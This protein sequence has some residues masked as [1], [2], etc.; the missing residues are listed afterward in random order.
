[1]QNIN[2]IVF[3]SGLTLVH[4]E[5]NAAPV[6]ALMVWVKAGSAVEKPEEF[7]IAHMCEH[8]V[9]KG[10][11]R[12]GVGEISHLAE[13]A[14]GD[15]NAW[16]S[17]D[18]TVF[19]ITLPVSQ[20]DLGMDILADMLLHPSIDSLELDRERE[21]IL[22]ELRRGEDSP[23]QTLSKEL[24]AASYGE[25][26]YSHPI[27][28]TQKT[29]KAQTAETL[30]AFI[31]RHYIPQNIIVTI[32]G[33]INLKAA[34]KMVAKYWPISVK[35]GE[36]AKDPQKLPAL[37]EALR[38]GQPTLKIVKAEKEESHLALSWSIPS[39]LHQDMPALDILATI[40]GGASSS[41]LPLILR[42]SLQLVHN[43]DAYAFTPGK[44]GIFI[45]SAALE[46]A[47]IENALKKIMAEVERLS[48]ELITQAELAKARFIL[49][50]LALQQMETV[51]DL[52]KD[53]ASNEQLCAN[54][55]E[56]QRYNNKLDMV[57]PAE[58]LRVARRYLLTPLAAVILVPKK[59]NLP[60]KSH[61]LKLLSPSKE[62]AKVH[63]G[64][65]LS[66]DKHGWYHYDLPTGGHIVAQLDDH[67]PLV[68]CSIAYPGG[69]RYETPET[70]G[71]DSFLATL[72]S[73]STKNRS[74]EKMVALLDN[75]AASINGFAGRN[76]IGLQ[77]SFLAANIEETLPL[78]LE[79]LLLP[80]F[81]K[82][83]IA[84]VRH[85]TMERIRS[86][87]DRPATLCRDLLLQGLYG[88]NHPFGQPAGGT[89]ESVAAIAQKAA[90]AARH[91]QIILAGK[92]VIALCG[93]FDPELI[94]EIVADYYEKYALKAQP[95]PA[96][97]PISP[98]KSQATLEK[99]LDKEQVHLSLGFL[100][101][102]F[103][104]AKERWALTL[105]ETILSGQSGRLFTKLRDEE[106]LAYTVNSTYVS[107]PLSGYFQYYIAVSPNKVAKAKEGLLRELS[108]L[109]KY[110]LKAEELE[111]ARNTLLGAQLIENQYLQTR[112]HHISLD[113]I[114]NLGY[115]AYLRFS[116]DLQKITL[117]DIE[118]AARRYLEPD[119][120]IWAQ[121]GPC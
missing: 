69:Q 85:L 119:K 47:S 70:A 17:Y 29:I 40:L 100:A 102:N 42:D 115:D 111:K 112:T 114:Y 121:V 65:A 90:L 23:Y 77:G 101:P 28:G 120:A 11:E 13:S 75:A 105:L 55:D 76:S 51:Q 74:R 108:N 116:D 1:M 37:E 106:S 46:E 98:I 117:S 86:R 93:S 94:I 24:F 83:E 7:G 73:F 54:P 61:L 72:F 12:R 84:L 118:E 33:D 4:Q 15:I 104:R 35:P 41:R 43:I 57:T 62:D 36:E 52:A 26:P 44:R 27:I 88:A 82:S 39:F 10:T 2:R 38:P 79:A 97:V 50:S 91:Q 48:H 60:P 22:E 68:S 59:A 5:I 99:K 53:Y 95:L 30:R 49:K 6:V 67:V 3:D 25:E 31:K 45:V 78:M 9:F 32:V 64:L 96:D 109:I 19:H 63:M 113:G 107:G 110:G 71:I 56:D 58:L 66:R 89:K 103:A 8:M 21:V 34:K 20:A 87:N 14:G 81:K 16:T 80:A 18:E 92:P